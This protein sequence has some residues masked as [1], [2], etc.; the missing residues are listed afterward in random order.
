MFV[1]CSQGVSRSASC[2]I[3]YLMHKLQLPYDA[4][5]KQVK[6]A[7][8]VTNPNIGFICQAR[9]LQIACCHIISS[10]I[11]NIMSTRATMTL[12]SVTIRTISL[13]NTVANEAHHQRV[14]AHTLLHSCCSGRNGSVPLLLQRSSACTK[15]LLSR[16]GLLGFW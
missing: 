11:I 4:V 15:W 13:I 12:Q 8:G 10:N 2:V 5:F 14:F 3:A 7:R 1:H 6:Q 9:N 16:S